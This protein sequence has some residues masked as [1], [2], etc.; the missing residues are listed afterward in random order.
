MKKWDW[1]RGETTGSGLARDNG[2]GQRRQVIMPG[3]E[4]ANSGSRVQVRSQL[5]GVLWTSQL[6]RAT[7]DMSSG[8]IVTSVSCTDT[9]SHVERRSLGEVRHGP[10]RQMQAE[11]LCQV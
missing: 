11:R 5:A 10:T 7:N 3:T 4:S 6:R 9:G 1:E 8:V 2:R